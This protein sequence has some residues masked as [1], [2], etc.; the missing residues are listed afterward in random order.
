MTRASLILIPIKTKYIQF[1]PSSQVIVEARN[2]V[3]EELQ[4]S[5][6]RNSEKVVSPQMHGETIDLA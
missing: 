6:G 3:V 2:S 1:T 5:V 4:R